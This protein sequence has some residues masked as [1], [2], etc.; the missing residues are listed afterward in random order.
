MKPAAEVGAS[1]ATGAIVV[2]TVVYLG[3]K[4]NEQIIQDTKDLD[5]LEK[6]WIQAWEVEVELME[7]LL[8][9]K[10]MRRCRDRQD[11]QGGGEGGGRA[12][13]GGQSCS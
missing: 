12:T 13:S 2:G 1:L 4:V 5:A 8:E 10:R 3:E 11:G 6:S 7:M 9:L